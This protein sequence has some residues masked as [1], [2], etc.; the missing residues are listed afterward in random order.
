M[1]SSGRT[2]LDET[3]R[4]VPPVRTATHARYF[5]RPRGQRHP[6]RHHQERYL[7]LLLITKCRCSQSVHLLDNTQR[8]T[9]HHIRGKR[10]FRPQQEHEHAYCPPLPAVANPRTAACRSTSLRRG[11]DPSALLVAAVDNRVGSTESISN[12]LATGQPPSRLNFSW[13]LKQLA[14]SGTEAAWMPNSRR[15]LWH[16][17]RSLHS[18]I[19]GCLR[20]LHV[21][22]RPLGGVLCRGAPISVARGIGAPADC[23]RPLLNVV[24]SIPD[25]L[26]EQL[27][28]TH[29]GQC[30]QPPPTPRSVAGPARVPPVP[31]A[32]ARRIWQALRVRTDNVT[33]LAREPESDRPRPAGFRCRHQGVALSPQFISPPL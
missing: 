20:D 9:I 15:D 6:F 18:S 10:C 22:V 32:A 33:N 16:Q 12:E 14:F 11:L 30:C 2:T 27:G 7:G 8:C 21:V 13:A 3:R 28:G 19:S 24:H 25:E 4:C 31:A 5:P 17:R 23:A 26:I 29:P 1:R